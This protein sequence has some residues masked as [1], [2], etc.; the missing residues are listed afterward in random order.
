MACLLGEETCGLKGGGR[1]SL[2]ASSV[3][4]NEG[5]INHGTP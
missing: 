1:R 2:T 3:E 4:E 5:S